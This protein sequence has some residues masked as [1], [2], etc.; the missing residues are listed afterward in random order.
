MPASAP[1]SSDRKPAI[2]VID[3]EEAM[4]DLI[5][6]MLQRAGFEPVPAAGGRE[7]LEYFHQRHIDAVV[8][9]MVMP[10]MDGIEV[11]RALLAERPGLPIVAVSGVDDWADYI[12]LATTLGAKAGLRKPLRSIELV[13][14]LRE[15]LA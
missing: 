2:L 1:P 11:I 9:D 13:Q 10:D 3:D 8:T 15:C 5:S 4:R 7:A 12:S 6:R 14:A